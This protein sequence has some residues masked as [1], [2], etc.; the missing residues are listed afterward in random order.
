MKS[1]YFG[2][3]RDLFKYDLVMKIMQAGLFERF[4]FIPMRTQNDGTRNGGKTNRHLAKAGFK[5][6][7]LVRFLD[8]CISENRRNIGQI[9]DF[10]K[11]R[12]IDTRIFDSEFTHENRGEY[13]EQVKDEL[14]PASLIFVDPDNGLEVKRSGEKHIS[15]KEARNLY[16]NMDGSSI[17]MISQCFPREEHLGYL[18]KRAEDIK[19]RIAEDG[20]VCIDDEDTILFFLTKDKAIE[21]SL[22]HIIGHYAEEYS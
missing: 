14:S 22:V 5:N 16:E 6:K 4:I 10:F 9:V 1:Q 19:E 18:H 13:F 8:E 7:E 15:Y 21:D 2:D 12:G 3:N 17:L 20:T 11:D